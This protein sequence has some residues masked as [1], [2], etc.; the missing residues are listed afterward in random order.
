MNLVQ[1]NK[2]KPLYSIEY[3]DTFKFNYKLQVHEENDTVKNYK[4]F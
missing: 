4:T 1:L 2:L 3:C